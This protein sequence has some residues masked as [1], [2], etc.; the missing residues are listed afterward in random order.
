M[1]E[2]DTLTRS[3]L[4]ARRGGF[5]GNGSADLVT[6]HDD[7]KSGTPDLKRDPGPSPARRTAA[8]ALA[9]ANERRHAEKL[10]RQAA[11]NSVYVRNQD[12]GS[13]MPLPAGAT[14]ANVEGAVRLR[15]VFGAL[16]AESATFE[17]ALDPETF[18]PTTVTAWRG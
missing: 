14:D 17:I 9:A 15:S 1:P 3:Q 2:P 18:V 5:E 6:H 7:F 16:L 10:A 4:E 8:Q 11:N 13:P 12:D